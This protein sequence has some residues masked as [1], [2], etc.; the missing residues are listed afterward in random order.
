MRP[1]CALDHEVVPTS[2]QPI[3]AEQIDLDKRNRGPWQHTEKK[4]KERKN[5]KKKKKKKKE[6]KFEKEKSGK[7]CC[8]CWPSLASIAAV[9]SF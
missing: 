1:A 6:R 9:F 4:K 2:A 5:K 3:P 7:G 8:C